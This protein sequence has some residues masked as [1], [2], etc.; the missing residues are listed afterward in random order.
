MYLELVWFHYP[1]VSS[2]EML[3]KSLC[4]RGEKHDHV[5]LNLMK[6]VLCTIDY[7]YLCFICSSNSTSLQRT[8]YNSNNSNSVCSVKTFLN[9]YFTKL[10]MLKGIFILFCSVLF[11]KVY[12][13]V[14]KVFAISMLDNNYVYFYAMCIFNA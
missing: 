14:F 5:Y 7:Q 3:L 9:W 2:S 13:Y 11:L 1:L 8:K 6:I 12:I 4:R 10:V